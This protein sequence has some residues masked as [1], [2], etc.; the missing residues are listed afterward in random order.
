MKTIRKPPH[1]P[2]MTQY[3]R[4]CYLVDTHQA[5]DYSEA[6]S[7]LASQPRRRKPAPAQPVVMRYPYAND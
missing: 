1:W 3:A 2:G 5:R 4:R 7:M 6:C